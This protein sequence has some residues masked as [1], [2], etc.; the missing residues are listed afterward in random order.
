MRVI[1]FFFFKQKTAYEIPKRDWSSDVC[2][3]DLVGIPTTSLVPYLGYL[4]YNGVVYRNMYNNSLLTPSTF[5]AQW[6]VIPMNPPLIYSVVPPFVQWAS[7]RGRGIP[8]NTYIIQVSN[9]VATLNNAP[10]QIL[11][12]PQDYTMTVNYSPPLTITL[13]ATT[14][15]V[16][17][18]KSYE[19]KYN[20]QG[21]LPYVNTF[22]AE[23]ARVQAE[24]Q[25]VADVES[26]TIASGITQ[27]ILT[28]IQT[29]S[30][31]SRDPIAT[32]LQHSILSHNIRRVCV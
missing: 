12:G 20:F 25:A 8:A 9:G 26:A 2:S 19:Q 4:S 24:I 30:S 16:G 32:A 17:N 15:N 29:S 11:S 14:G 21:G 3:S 7:F 10:T 5:P 23:Q 22:L 31:I 1:G 13:P 28:A 27:G 6:N 18:F